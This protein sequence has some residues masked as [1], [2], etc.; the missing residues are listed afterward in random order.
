MENGGLAWR[1]RV[2]IEELVVAFRKEDFEEAKTP[3]SKFCFSLIKTSSI[4]FDCPQIKATGYIFFDNR[5]NLSYVAKVSLW[6][7]QKFEV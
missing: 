3:F 4:K 2:G 7:G 6:P 5:N 1:R